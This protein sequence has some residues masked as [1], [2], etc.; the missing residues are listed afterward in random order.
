MTAG[1]ILLT[2]YYSRLR[3]QLKKQQHSISRQQL[4]IGHME[5]LLEL[6]V[7]QSKMNPHF[8]FN[9][10]NAVQYFIS[11]GD[12][13]A[14]MQYMHHFSSFLRSMIRFGDE[15]AVSIGNETTLLEQYLWLE[16]NR[17]P[18]RF[19][20]HIALHGD[21]KQASILPLLT[22]V[23]VEEALYQHLLVQ[24]PQVKGYVNISFAMQEQHLQVEV[25]DNGAQIMKPPALL[26]DRIALYNHHTDRKIE[27]RQ[28]TFPSNGRLLN[29]M[30]LRIPQPLF[31]PLIL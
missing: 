25:T 26:H 19:E 27:L 24:P 30:L 28:D 12:K 15:P 10:L 2:A 29:R 20:Y 5:R 7:L 3:W 4:K 11:S 16:Q 23:L 6:K 21:V 1:A 31:E 18:E 13:V 8:I 17:F 9:S 22:H 14:S